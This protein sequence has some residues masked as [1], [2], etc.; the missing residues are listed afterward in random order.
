MKRKHEV[1]LGRTRTSFLLLLGCFLCSLWLA[2]PGAS[3]AEAK[4]DSQEAGHPLRIAAYVLHPIGVLIE[5]A[6][7]RP[8]YH[9]VQQ[10]PLAT[11][12][13]AEKRPVKSQEEDCEEP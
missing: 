12:F 11:I 9:A 10:E 5:Y 3:A 6:V 4:F 8:A 13:G 2:A 7:M 1:K